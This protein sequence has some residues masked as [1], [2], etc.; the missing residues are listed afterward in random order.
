VKDPDQDIGFITYYEEPL[1][2][3]D[4]FINVSMKKPII[5]AVIAVSIISPIITNNKPTVRSC[6]QVVKDAK[7]SSF[8]FLIL[9]HIT[10]YTFV[11]F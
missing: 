9:I 8:S 4:Y 3:G 10:Y 1:E 2:P 7:F 11:R 6:I 5:I